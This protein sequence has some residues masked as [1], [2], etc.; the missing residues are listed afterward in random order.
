MI[1]VGV[2]LFAHIILRVN[3]GI[4]KKANVITAKPCEHNDIEWEK[5]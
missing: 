2:G 1:H 4:V 3:A 5:K